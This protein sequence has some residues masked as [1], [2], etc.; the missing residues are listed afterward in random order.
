MSINNLEELDLIMCT[1]YRDTCELINFLKNSNLWEIYNDSL[2]YINRYTTLFL[3]KEGF[4]SLSEYAG[5]I[6]EFNIITFRE[7]KSLSEARP[8]SIRLSRKEI[9][10]LK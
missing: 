4:I 7:W 10:Y 1:T 2:Q 9:K 8:Q 6:R 3:K 5:D